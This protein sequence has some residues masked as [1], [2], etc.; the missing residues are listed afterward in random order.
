MV[1]WV[2]VA[3]GGKGEVDIALGVHTVLSD[4]TVLNNSGSYT[5]G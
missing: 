1:L 3:G 2:C 4:K 5:S